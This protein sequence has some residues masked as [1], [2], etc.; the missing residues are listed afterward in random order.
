MKRMKIKIIKVP[1]TLETRINY[2][3]SGNLQ[4]CAFMKLD[5][6][7]DGKL[8]KTQLVNVLFVF[9]VVKFIGFLSC[10]LLGYR[11][12]ASDFQELICGSADVHIF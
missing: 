3:P 7:Q 4:P 11:K 9:A 10:L 5:M 6:S 8:K 12:E 1:S 2:I